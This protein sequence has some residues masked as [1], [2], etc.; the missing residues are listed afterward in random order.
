MLALIAT[1]DENRL[2]AMQRRSGGIG[3]A[4]LYREII[5]VSLTDEAVR[6][7]HPHGL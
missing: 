7:R 5:D 2:R 6:Q 3:A 1:L 4:D